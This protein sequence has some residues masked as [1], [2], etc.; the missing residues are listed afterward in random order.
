M[1][2]SGVQQR[3]SVMYMFFFVFF[4]IMVYYKILNIGLRVIQQDLIVGLFYTVN[5]KLP[6]YPSPSLIF[7]SGNNTFVSDTCESV[8]ILS[9]SSFISFI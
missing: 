7:P 5:P 9:V 2:V 3:D 4:S 8:C 1:L 6:I